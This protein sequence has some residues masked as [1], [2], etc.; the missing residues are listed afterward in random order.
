MYPSKHN[1]KKE[2]EKGEGEFNSESLVAEGC[3]MI[4]FV[5]IGWMTEIWVLMLEDFKIW[6]WKK[7]KILYV[8]FLCE[9]C[10]EVIRL[11]DVGDVL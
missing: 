5:E 2:K 3:M 9:V 7:E 11:L 6:W 10:G 8:Y 1:N 4:A